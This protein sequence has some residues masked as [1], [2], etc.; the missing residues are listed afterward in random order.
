MLDTLR[1]VEIPEGV[2]IGLRVAGPPVRL[3]A[4]GID[5]AIRAMIYL[6]LAMALPPMGRF[7]L[8][9]W[10]ITIFLVEWFYPVLFEVYRHGATPGKKMMGIR[11]IQ[12]DGAP[13]GWPPSLV[14]NLLRSAD[15]LPLCYGAGIVSMLINKDFKRLGDIT[16]GTTVVYR[17]L[18]EVIRVP[19][20]APT[21]PPVRLTTDEQRALIQFAERSEA[22]TPERRQELA[23]I[24][25]PLTGNPGELATKRLYQYANWMVGR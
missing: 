25:T 8:G 3:L 16:A 17:E 21:V 18:S 24:L 23:E 10:L 11:V 5:F 4:W 13:I 14:R 6:G 20:A 22:L 12:D 7:G 15:F 19:E 1:E 2:E 9:L